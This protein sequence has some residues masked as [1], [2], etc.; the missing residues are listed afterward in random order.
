MFMIPS[1]FTTWLKEMFL[2]EHIDY[3]GVCATAYCLLFGTY[4]EVVKVGDSWET[5]G[6]YKRWWQGDLWKQFFHEFLNIKGLEKE[7]LPNIP[8][9]RKRFQEVFF[10]TKMAKHLE[11]ARD[12]VVK[13]MMS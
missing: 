13:G 3:F 6:S 1:V 10:D 5:K 8:V 11:R 2:G 4:L 12:D 9:W 7:H